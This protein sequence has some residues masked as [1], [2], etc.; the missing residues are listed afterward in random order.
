MHFV[1][2]MVCM[3]LLEILVFGISD[4]DIGYFPFLDLTLSR[5]EE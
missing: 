4:M 2:V 5:S 3:L 1:A